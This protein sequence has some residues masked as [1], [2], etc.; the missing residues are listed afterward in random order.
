[1]TETD[2]C[3]FSF[4]TR[5]VLHQ[6]H[7]IRE[8]KMN[9]QDEAAAMLRG[10]VARVRE[11]DAASHEIARRLREVYLEAKGSGFNIRAV[12]TITRQHPDEAKGDADAAIAY[13]RALGGDALAQR[14][15]REDLGTV[16]FG[17]DRW[18][19][20]MMLDDLE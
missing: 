19:S 3:R 10:F 17:T 13:L 12:K 5:A 14:L 11:L 15:G 9:H 4:L 16:L 7:H 20:E 2:H 18:P 1:L 8:L 6:H